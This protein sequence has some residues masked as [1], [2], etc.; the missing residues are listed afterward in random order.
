MPETASA[1]KWPDGLITWKQLVTLSKLDAPTVARCFRN[2]WAAWAEVCGI[3]P[4]ELLDSQ[5]SSLVN[6][7]A[8][9]GRGVADGFDPA[10]QILALSELPCGVDVDAQLRSWINDHEDWTEEFFTA[11][12]VHEIG[13]SLGLSHDQVGTI[14]APYYDPGV[15]RPT[16]RDIDQVVIRYGPAKAQTSPPPS[17]GPAGPDT[18]PASGDPVTIGDRTVQFQIDEEGEYELSLYVMGK[19]FTITFDADAPGTYRLS[20]SLDRIS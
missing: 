18:P 8:Q 13:H 11:V 14:M 7:T 16:A 10:N 3:E 17:P 4:H 12:L 5:S 2:A 1:C 15:T 20:L 9:L 19:P 6:V